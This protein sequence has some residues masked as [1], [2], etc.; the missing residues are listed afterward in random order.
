MNPNRSSAA[1]MRLISAVCS[2]SR[3]IDSVEPRVDSVEPIQHRRLELLV[4]H[5]VPPRFHRASAA[6]F[7]LA[8]RASAVIFAARTRPPLAGSGGLRWSG[9]AS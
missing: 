6:A 9:G 7:A 2:S 3:V 1:C 4:A 8:D 5:A